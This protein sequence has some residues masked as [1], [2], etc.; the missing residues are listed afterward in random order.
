MELLVNPWNSI[1]GLGWVANLPWQVAVALMVF[2]Q[3]INLPQP[4]HDLGAVGEMYGSWV[5]ELI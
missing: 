3:L 1:T 4:H 2:R 5:S